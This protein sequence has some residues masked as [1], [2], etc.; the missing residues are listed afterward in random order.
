MRLVKDL[1]PTNV[2]IRTDWN[3]S[4]WSNGKLFH[5]TLRMNLCLLEMPP[6]LSRS[7]LMRTVGSSELDSMVL[8]LI[9][10]DRFDIRCDLAILHLQQE[11]ARTLANHTQKS[12]TRLQNSHRNP[13]AV[14]IVHARHPAFPCNESRTNRIWRPFRRGVR[15]RRGQFRDGRAEVPNTG[16]RRQTP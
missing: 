14:V 7:R 11:H 13:D 1:Y 3:M 4:I 15:S 16:R 9:R 12:E 6:H 10:S 5:N 2:R 8:G